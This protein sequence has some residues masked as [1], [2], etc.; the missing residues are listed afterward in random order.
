MNSADLDA[1]LS[2]FTS[3][4]RVFIPGGTGEPLAL[5]RMLAERPDC[6]D[7]VRMIGC[8]IPGMNDFDYAGL[9]P[10]AHLTTYMFPPA[11][12]ASFEAGRVDLLPLAYSQIAEHLAEVAPID[13]AILQV[14]PPDADG[15]CSFGVSADFPP[16]IWRRAGRRIGLVNPNLPRPARAAK[17][18]FSALDVTVEAPAAVVEAADTPVSAE[19]AAITA[20]VVELIPD[21]AALQTG[22]G[23]APAA[24]YEQLTGHK[25]I[26]IR[27]GMITPGFRTLAESGALAPGGHITGVALGTADFYRWLAQNDV[28][29]FADARITHGPKALSGIERFVSIGGALEVDLFGQV[30]LEWRGDRMVSGVGGAP[31]FIR[32]ASRSPGGRAIIALPSSVGAGKISRIVPRLSSPTA[33]IGRNDIDTVVTEFGAASLGGLSLD[34]RA[35]ALIAIAHP[36]HQGA[37]EEAWRAIRSKL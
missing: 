24:I 27:S 31:D 10:G 33:S 14:S 30:N 22:I 8:L 17:I 4:A 15:L 19:V 12:R 3:G 1:V 7:G 13:A 20:R 2:A 6:L 36:A 32:A 28:V 16:L 35:A 26:T 29:A 37:L 23:G 18:P 25:G 5:R 11:C 34:R 9:H 21:G